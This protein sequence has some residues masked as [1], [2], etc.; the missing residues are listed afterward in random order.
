MV[1]G[2]NQG[3]TDIGRFSDYV[4]GVGEINIPVYIVGRTKNGKWVGLYTAVVE[5]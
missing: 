3:S 5:T 1:R 2:V 4:C